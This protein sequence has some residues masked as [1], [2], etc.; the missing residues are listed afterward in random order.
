MALE[1]DDRNNRQPNQESSTE[2]G[3]INRSYPDYEGVVVP[4]GYETVDAFLEEARYEFQADMDADRENRDAGMDDLHF[5]GVDQ[6]D[7]I[8]RAEREAA[9]RPCLTVNTLPQFIGQVIGDRRMNKTSIKVVP[10]IGA[11]V[12]EAE[13]R[14]GI[15]KS[16]ESFSNAE[17]VYDA[18]FEDQVSCGIGNYRI[19]MDYADDDVFEQEIKI[20]QI[21]NPFAVVWDRM[22]VDPTGRDAGHCF[23]QDVMPRKAYEARW[24]DRFPPPAALTDATVSS[25]TA[26]GWMDADTV[27]I[28][29]YWRIVK[30]KA[31]LAMMKDGSVKDVTG[32]PEAEYA[33]D[34]MLDGKGLPV[35]RDTRRTFAVMYL[36]TG[37]AIL[38][39]PYELPVTRLP[40]IRVSGREVRIGD[41]RIRYS[42]VRWAKDPSRLRNYWRSTAAETLALAPKNQWLAQRKSVKG[43]ED[44]FRQAH[45]TNDPLLIYNDGTEA[46]KRE[47]GPQLPDAVLREATMNAQ[48]IKDV[49]GLQ[50]A[51]LGIRSNEVSGK[52]IMARQ[53]EGDVATVIYHDNLHSAIQEGGDVV[54][55]LI[56][57][58]YDT[59]R[60]LRIIGQDE[61]IKLVKVN[62][63]MDP[64]APDLTKGKYDVMITTGP[65][66]TTQRMESA[67]A[68]M[69]A[70]QVAPHLMQVAGDLVVEAQ[71][72]PGAAAIAER[73]KK[74]MPPEL[75]K[76]EGEPLTPEEARAQQ[77][78]DQQKQLQLTA[79]AEEAELKTKQAQLAI[80]EAEA[81]VL[82]A[83]EDARAAAAN[84]D[85]AESLA[86]REELELNA[87]QF[88]AGADAM[89]RRPGSRPDS[90]SSSVAT[91]PGSQ[92]GRRRQRRKPKG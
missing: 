47:Q 90:S 67:E 38:D 40:I 6:W 60:T 34:V 21:A 62:D 81:R 24:G 88:H 12:E 57:V 76:P 55:Q 44:D 8:V 65:S 31:T 19:A 23:V 73:L 61:K 14:S 1:P 59:T 30:R 75:V 85:R 78:E 49:T 66:Y 79:A 29:E 22:S 18:A 2:G 43:L 54:Q 51:S 52:A 42:L 91:N 7:P 39:G 32:R 58:C 17:R 16:I 9:G 37:F 5:I 83:Q 11:T 4:A 33:A 89:D 26:G 87:A 15:I 92:S 71:D 77:L 50:D 72:W 64:K 82:Q 28:T 84:A 45:L 74:T 56:P 41:K 69:E 35:V 27:R 86:E 13:V 10:K 53:R 25:M 20:Q 70:I 46:P 63:P 80:A 48:D 36:I 68:M 3:Q